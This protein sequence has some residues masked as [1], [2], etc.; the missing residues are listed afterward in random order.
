M[1]RFQFQLLSR[2]AR[3][4]I[5]GTLKC[6]HKLGYMRGRNSVTGLI[7]LEHALCVCVYVCVYVCVWVGVCEKERVNIQM[8]GKAKRHTT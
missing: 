3:F 8:G 2:M 6:I 1:L 5:Y 4:S 7:V